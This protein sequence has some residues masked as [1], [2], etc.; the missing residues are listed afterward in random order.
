MNGE[1]FGARSKAGKSGNGK[2]KAITS[3]DEEQDDEDEEPAPNVDVPWHKRMTG[4]LMAKAC[5]E[6]AFKEIL[7]HHDNKGFGQRFNLAINEYWAGFT[8]EEKDDFSKKAREW[9]RQGPPK[10]MKPS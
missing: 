4:P 5:N 9:N 8:E 10:N 7:A 1:E 6:E 3:N 2:S